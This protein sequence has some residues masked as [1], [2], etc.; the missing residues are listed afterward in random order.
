MNLEADARL[1]CSTPFKVLAFARCELNPW[2][3]ICGNHF[4]MAH[5]SLVALAQR[6]FGRCDRLDSL[7]ERTDWRC[8][9]PD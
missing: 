9:E 6:C 2:L 7:P 1:A 3:A 5:Q 4:E 8:V